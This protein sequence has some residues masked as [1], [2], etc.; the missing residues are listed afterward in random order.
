MTIACNVLNAVGGHPAIDRDGFVPTYPM[1]LPALN[2]SVGA[3][4]G[5]D[6]APCP[7]TVGRVYL[8]LSRALSLSHPRALLVL[9]RV[10]ALLRLCSHPLHPLCLSDPPCPA[11]SFARFLASLLPC[12]F[13]A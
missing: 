11:L 3:F 10:P 4:D 6:P 9:T 8:S 12:L 13:A 2:I 1:E 5:R 7:Q